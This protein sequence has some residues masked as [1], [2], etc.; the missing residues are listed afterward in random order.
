MLHEVYVDSSPTEPVKEPGPAIARRL[1]ARMVRRMVVVPVLF[2]IGFIPLL[3]SLIGF[4]TAIVVTVSLLYFL[5]VFF[6][7]VRIFVPKTRALQFIADR[8]ITAMFGKERVLS[9]FEKIRD[10]EKTEKSNTTVDKSWKRHFSSSPT[11]AERIGNLES[12]RQ[13]DSGRNSRKEK[14]ILGPGR[15]S[16][17]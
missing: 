11:L 12:N 9:L 3:L 15:I 10:I 16:K 6:V 13:I 4:A 7:I 5:F 2:L 1:E 17:Q 8:E 14:N